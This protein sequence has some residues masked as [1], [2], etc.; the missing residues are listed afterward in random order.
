ML[1]IVLSS[2]LCCSVRVAVSF[3]CLFSLA[4]WSLSSALSFRLWKRTSLTA[5]VSCLL[6]CSSF[7]TPGSS[8]S[9]SCNW[10]HCPCSSLSSFCFDVNFFSRIVAAVGALAYRG[11]LFLVCSWK[12]QFSITDE[13]FPF[14]CYRECSRLRA[15]YL[16]TQGKS[17]QK[18]NTWTRAKVSCLSIL[19][20]TC[21]ESTCQASFARVRV[22][23][24]LDYVCEERDSSKS[25]KRPVS[26]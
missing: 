15:V 6:L 1:S 2:S 24:F 22:L 20:F 4:T 8:N 16:C 13:P 7:F 5:F 18:K 25:N 3:I 9:S 26:K 10:L 14:Q 11:F 23:F 12:M 17:S 19:P 21:R